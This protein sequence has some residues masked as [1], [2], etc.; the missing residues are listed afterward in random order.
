MD[1]GIINAF[2]I[3]YRTQV[4]S[5][6]ISQIEYGDDD[7]QFTV[8]DAINYIDYAWR[9]TT[10]STIQNCWRKAGFKASQYEIDEEGLDIIPEI[11]DIEYNE[12]KKKWAELNKVSKSFDFNHDEY[13]T[14]GDNVPFA[15]A[16][17]DDEIVASVQVNETE[18]NEEV[19]QG[20][21]IPRISNRDALKSFE[22]LKVYFTQCSE[23][24]SASLKLLEKIEKDLEVVKAQ[25]SIKSFFSI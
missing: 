19:E 4:V 17:T 3:L 6:R 23:D 20:E 18:E 11:I 22:C 1:Q 24:R 9:S 12:Y 21:E 14:V 13:I 15:G 10:T 25:P 8:L 16:L 5:R 7:K 2:K